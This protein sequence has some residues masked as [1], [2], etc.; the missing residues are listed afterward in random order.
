[1]I[2]VGLFESR[3]LV[4]CTANGT[5]LD[6]A[7]VRRMFRNI[8]GRAGLEAGAWTPRELRHAFVSL[9]S[10]AGVPLRRSPAWSATAAPR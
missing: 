4:F 8:C 9:M 6:S 3:E 5:A 10:D 7:D 1:M 2:E